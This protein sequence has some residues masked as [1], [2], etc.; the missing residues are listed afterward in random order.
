MTISRVNSSRTIVW[1]ALTVLG[2]A[3]GAVA[4]TIWQ[5]RSDAYNNAIV[6]TN[7]LGIVLAGET[8]RSV[9]AVDLILKDV[10]DRV[11]L[12]DLETPD[13][14]RQ[15]LGTERFRQFILE[16]LARLP[17]AHAIGLA[18][19]DGKLIV[20]TSAWPT[21]NLD[22]PD[23]D[24]FR[25]A[26]KRDG[27]GLSIGVPVTDR[28]SGELILLFAKRLF[29][30]SDRPFGVVF[31]GVPI[32][33][34]QHLSESVNALHDQSFLLVRTDGTILL[35]YPYV[36]SASGKAIPTPAAW[37]RAVKNGGGS[38]RVAG[39]FDGQSRVVS[40]FPLRDYPLVLNVTLAENA[41]LA[42]WRHRAISILLGTIVILG[43]SIFLLY[44]VARQFRRLS[45]SETALAE[46][47][48]D[49][50]I[51]LAQFGTA[52][53]NMSH[54]LCMFDGSGRLVV[55]NERFRAMYRLPRDVCRRGRSFRE[56]LEARQANGTLQGDPHVMFQDFLAGLSIGK[57][58]DFIA[59]L[60]DDRVIAIVRRSMKGG[61][62]VETHEDISERHRSAAQIAHIARHDPLTDLGN[63]IVF[64][65]KVS[66][67]F[68]KLERSGQ[69][70]ALL[71]LDL[72]HF[73]VVNDS[74]GHPAGDQLLKHAAQRLVDVTR[75]TDLVARMGGDEFAV[76]QTASPDEP[77]SATNL[78]NRIIDALGEPFE[79]NGQEVNVGISI[80]IAL[81][82]KDGTTADELLK[83][84]DLALYRAKADGRN[85]LRYFEP[86]MDAAARLRHSLAVDLRHAIAAEEF[87]IY[88][89]PVIDLETEQP[90]G[91][92]ALAR[93]HHPQRGTIKPV[94]FI[95]LAEDTGLINDL[96][97]LVLGK[98]C[99][100][101]LN[102]PADIKL[103]VNL[104]PAQFRKSQIV[105]LVETA[106]DRT[107][108]SAERLELEITESVLLHQNAENLAILR[109]LKSLGVAIVLDDFG[110]GYSSLSYLQMFPFDKIKIDRSFVSQL[111]QRLDS[112][113]IV[114][115]I[116]GLARS[117]DVLTTA[118]GVE[119]EEQLR[120]L[121]AAGCT[122][123]QGFL[124]GRPRP[125][126]ELVLDVR[127]QAA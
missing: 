95:A 40:V 32:T 68:R 49:L 69:A 86:A 113:A 46:K 36:E 73:K 51:A 107:G 119:T 42:T 2:L 53:N 96:S 6:E 58:I 60:P 67:A 43:C 105:G 45:A 50:E 102:W 18:D 104:S 26:R 90:C 109:R 71:L 77:D 80:G 87:E 83:H 20:T 25:H 74:L 81:A 38:Y 55:C 27:R 116:T 82:P 122:Q 12:F 92:E 14:F 37:Y 23:R 5:L 64:Q 9:Q 125:A 1:G 15:V 115:A 56:I 93:W 4:L 52:L 100:E 22:L 24:Y 94:D 29:G 63:R 117:L 111:T 62:W 28:I 99:R 54:G 85:G 65:E 10:Q 48:R 35:R 59:N 75:D 34:F 7:N 91:A 124:F 31:M 17:Q 121:R 101:A 110:T 103:A 112:A 120:T 57:E 21:P 8:A 123:A 47:S 72:D 106:L 30:A 88:Y 78:A 76:L 126:R 61:G 41:V 118:E 13:E 66:E 16:R 19:D 79:L 97:E 84:A 44:H 127:L 114:A 33:Y 70:F 98:A 39:V 89:Q 3:V 11:G 108:L